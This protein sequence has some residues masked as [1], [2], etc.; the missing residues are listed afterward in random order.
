MNNRKKPSKQA[1]DPS[2]IVE[3][4][5]REP[6]GAPTAELE[7]A[8]RKLIPASFRFVRD[9]GPAR[10]K[11]A[12]S[13]LPGP[14][15]PEPRPAGG[16]RTIA[17]TGPKTQRAV[18]L[19]MIEADFPGG[20]AVPKDTKRGRVMEWVQMRSMEPGITNIE[21]AKRMGIAVSYLNGCISQARKEGWLRFEDPMA[22]ME[23]EIVP[24]TID[25]LSALLDAKDKTAT[26]ETAKGTIFKSYL[27]SQGI[28]EQPQTVLALRID[29]A[30]GTNMNIVTGRIVGRAK[31]G[32]EVE[33]E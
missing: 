9:G 15:A 10:P 1:N 5:L 22:R 28:S 16:E 27:S 8:P 12:I 21:C 23:F 17:I 14:E 7:R 33:A 3:P 32:S 19:G 30:D 20:I 31:H 29:R 6:I 13:P 18:A 2:R 26:I 24:K 11:V 25:N 4:L